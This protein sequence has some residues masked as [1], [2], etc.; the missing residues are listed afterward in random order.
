[1][2]QLE[3]QLADDGRRAVT[4]MRLRDRLSMLSGKA[5]AEID[6]PERRQARRVLRSIAA[7][8]SGR[9]QDR[10]YLALVERYRLAGR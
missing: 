10:E 4:L 9:G 3:T 7:G 6:T 2:F 1:M 5:T 8:A